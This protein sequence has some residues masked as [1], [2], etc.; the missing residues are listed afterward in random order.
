MLRPH[1]REDPELL[2]C[3]GATQRM[4]NAAI[5]VDGET[6]IEGELFG[7]R[8]R[9]VHTKKLVS[10]RRQKEFAAIFSA[11]HRFE[12]VFRMWH[13]ANDIAGSVGNTSDVMES[14]VW[15]CRFRYLSGVIDITKN[16]LS[17]VF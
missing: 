8:G 14:A 4:Q 3:G 7:N 15:V 9:F 10:E 17:I 16:D 13:Q 12:R 11:K 2:E 6:M 1:H 5:L